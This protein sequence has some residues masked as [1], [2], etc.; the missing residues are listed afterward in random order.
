MQRD[1]TSLAKVHMSPM[2]FCFNK[3]LENVFLIEKKNSNK[4]NVI[5]ISH[6]HNISNLNW[7]EIRYNQ[8]DNVFITKSS[9]ID[10]KSKII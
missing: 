6:S 8:Y 7:N 5:F 1:E 9:I 2:I 3:F 4:R 10:A